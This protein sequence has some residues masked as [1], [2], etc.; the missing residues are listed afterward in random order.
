MTEENLNVVVD[1][2]KECNCPICKILRSDEA[3]KFLAVV[4]ASFIGC[5]L[6][7]VVFAPKK[8]HYPPR[9]QAPCMRMM[10]RPLP[11]Q[12]EYRDRQLPPQGE[13]RGRHDRQDFR[14]FDGPRGEG[15]GPND[16]DFRYE[17][18]RGG[19]EIN[20]P[21]KD[22]RKDLKIKGNC[23]LKNKLHQAPQQPEPPSAQ[24]E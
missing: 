16:R 3:K 23:P 5:S 15:I 24:Q 13:F 8:H 9:N 20:H 17:G 4:L 1:D 2:K 14:N 18:P 22:F 12:G 10:D 21:R 7:L 11:P 19:A 6:A